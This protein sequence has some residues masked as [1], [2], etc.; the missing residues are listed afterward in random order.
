MGKL[1]STKTFAILSIISFAC[2][3]RSGILQQIDITCIFSMHL[4]SEVLTK[5]LSLSSLCKDVLLGLYVV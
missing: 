3:N 4:W 2:H 1:G 5:D